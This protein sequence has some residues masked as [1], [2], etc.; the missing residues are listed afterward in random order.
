MHVALQTCS[1]DTGLCYGGRAACC[2]AWSKRKTIL[3]FISLVY[4]FFHCFTSYFLCSMAVAFLPQRSVT[5]KAIVRNFQNTEI[6]KKY[7]KGSEKIEELSQNITFSRATIFAF[8]TS[9]SA[10]CFVTTSIEPCN[11]L[12]FSL[13][14]LPYY[15]LPYP[16][17]PK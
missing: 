9:S 14:A 15:S 2:I 13:V 7:L 16:P 11:F 12:S 1:N 8:R 17:P 4:L 6:F 5:R 10:A 3:M